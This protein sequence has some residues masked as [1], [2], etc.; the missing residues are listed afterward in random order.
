MSK[1]MKVS[2]IPFL[3]LPVFILA[4]CLTETGLYR[5]SGYNQQ[6][7]DYYQNPETAE[8]FRLQMEATVLEA[9]KDGMRVAPGL[10][11]EIGTLYL[12]KGDR[13]GAVSWYKKERETW[14]ESVVLM[15]ALI[16]N[17]EKSDS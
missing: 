5:W 15:D 1:I 12:Q 16:L 14:P 2:S 4:G 10:Y 6:L 3:L 17:L 13:T 11:A 8:E 9:E 7:F